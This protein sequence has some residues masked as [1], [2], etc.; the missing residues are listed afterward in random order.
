MSQASRQTQ[1]RPEAR[2]SGAL[3]VWPGW[4][5]RSTVGALPNTVT[6]PDGST[7][8]GQWR[9]RPSVAAAS[10]AARAARG[11]SSWG[12]AGRA[13]RRRSTAGAR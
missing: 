7:H 10:P 1:S 13:G 4:W 3:R 9:Y 11:A 8:P 2:P 5:G 12:T 6:A